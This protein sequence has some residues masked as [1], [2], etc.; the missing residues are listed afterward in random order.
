MEWTKG[1]ILS[2]MYIVSPFIFMILWILSAV[3]D[4]EW[5]FGELSLSTL[6]ISDNALSAALF[7]IACILMGAMIIISGYLIHRI[8]G[9]RYIPLIIA[10][11]GL[12]LLCVGIFTKAPATYD[13]HYT[14]AIT[15][16]VIGSL[17]VVH[18]IGIR[19]M[20]KQYT[21]P[22]ILALLGLIALVSMCFLEFPLAEAIAVII[23]MCW[24]ETMG[25]EMYLIRKDDGDE[26]Y[27]P[28]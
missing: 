6:G 11:D 1:R 12:M 24:F 14:V 5:K 4:G 15:F 19:V 23:G 25:I 22:V 16:G 8:N 3:T 27:V 17:L 9:A 20:R 10:A 7:N 28:F 21:V 26:N 13:I 2:V 18:C